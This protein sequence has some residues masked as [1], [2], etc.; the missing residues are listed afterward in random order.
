MWQNPQ[1]RIQ[2]NMYRIL[3]FLL[4]ALG[5]NSL[6]FAQNPGAGSCLFFNG[7][8]NYISIPHSNSLVNDSAITL[9]AWFL[10]GS[11]GS[12]TW[13]NVILGKDGWAQ[14]PQG[15]TLRCGGNG[16]LSFNFGTGSNW[17]EVLVPNVLQTQAWYH[18]AATFD[19]ST[20]RLY[21]N[22]VEIGT[23]NYSGTISSGNYDLNIARIPY[24]ITGPRHFNGEVDEVRVWRTALSP[25]TIR[26]WMCRK[27][28]ASH[29]DYAQLGGYWR[30]DDG[31]GPAL[32][33]LSPN[34]NTGTLVSAPLWGLSG[35]AIGDTSLYAYGGAVSLNM[36]GMTGG[37]FLLD[38]VSGT[39]DGVQLY[40]INE[41]PDLANLPAGYV[42]FDSSY[43][44]VY[45]ISNSS[46]TFDVTLDYGPN[47]YI[48][49]NDGCNAAIAGRIANN[50]AVWSD[51]AVTRDLTQSR[52][53]RSTIGAQ[54]FI[55]GRNLQP[56]PLVAL[57]HVNF[58]VGDT[59][60]LA[61][62]PGTGLSYA[63]YLN[64]SPISGAT[65]TNYFATQ[66]GDYYL[67]VSDSQCT[68]RTDTATVTVYALPAVSQMALGGVCIDAG[69]Q[70]LSGMP[71]GG[72]FSGPGI[73][74]GQFDPLQAGLGSSTVFYTFTDS[75]QCAATDS[76]FVTVHPTPSAVF[77]NPADVCENDPSFPLTGANPSGGTYLGPGVSANDF[78]PASVGPGNYPLQYVVVDSNGC[79]DTAAAA[80]T[81]NANPTTPTITLAGNTL[82][83]SAATGNQWQLNGTDIPGATANTYVMA[84]TGFY[85]L[86]VTDS[87][88]CVSD[89]SMGITFVGQAESE[90]IRW[91]VGPN[92]V[93]DRLRV[94]W[95]GSAGAN[96]ALELRDLRGRVLYH[97]AAQMDR[98]DG[99]A[100]ISL[101]DCAAGIYLLQLRIGERRV[102]AKVVRE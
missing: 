60:E 64:G 9:E 92:P 80:I 84:M 75:N 38:N 14:G 57:G 51:I 93:R 43:Y 1:Y 10:P 44:G 56:Y 25:N 71:I 30:F 101:V 50:S 4:L 12:N 94:E 34:S 26:D 47:P 24:A 33:D 36:P 99:R 96:Y 8:N 37:S 97:A 6:V 79:T 98:A 54:Q 2:S 86:I 52:L 39:P 59:A 66:A 102:T 17:Q 90:L 23:T 58:C 63:W 21:L 18:V 83:S 42:S 20:M 48:G 55:L 85:T 31:A 11:F 53:I 91:E 69:L 15:Y 81:V 32:T 28:T 61:T 19:G 82:T 29:P 95:A 78:F 3:Q 13:E 77:S 41:A 46:H 65:S 70:A 45:M 67:E 76:Q 16:A 27:V 88:G 74:G 5:M 72:S 100:E 40:R 62:N 35:A 89:P 68:W 22:G 73:S 49:A 87:N 7:T